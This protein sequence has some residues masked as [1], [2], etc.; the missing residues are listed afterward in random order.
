MGYNPSTYKTIT[1]DPRRVEEEDII[2]IDNTYGGE[3]VVFIQVKNQSL[4]SDKTSETVEPIEGLKFVIDQ[5]GN[6][7]ISGVDDT[8][9]EFYDN[10]NPDLDFWYKGEGSSLCFELVN[11][12][13][14][15]NPMYQYELYIAPAAGHPYHEYECYKNDFDIDVN[16]SK[17]ERYLEN[18]LHCHTITTPGRYQYAV[19]GKGE[20][21]GVAWHDQYNAHPVIKYQLGEFNFVPIDPNISI[22]LSSNSSDR[23]VMVNLG[24]LN[25]G[26]L[27][28]SSTKYSIISNSGFIEG[29]LPAGTVYI[30]TAGFEN[31]AIEFI[32]STDRGIQSA[33]HQV[34]VWTSPERFPTEGVSVLDCTE[35]C[36][37]VFA[38]IPGFLEYKPRGLVKR[39]GGNWS[40][41]DNGICVYDDQPYLKKLSF[42]FS[43]YNPEVL[44]DPDATIDEET[45]IEYARVTS[46]V[47]VERSEEKPGCLLFRP[48]TAEEYFDRTGSNPE[49]PGLTSTDGKGI[50]P[51]SSP[52]T[53]CP[54]DSGKYSNEIS[55]NLINQ[56]RDTDSTYG[57][58]YDKPW[59]LLFSELLA[60]QEEIG[61]DGKS[62]CSIEQIMFL[63]SDPPSEA[64]PPGASPD[65]T[66]EFFQFTFTSENSIGVRT[67][68]VG[69]TGRSGIVT[70]MYCLHDEDSL[71][72][73]RDIKTP[74][75]VDCPPDYLFDKN[76]KLGYYFISDRIRNGRATTLLDAPTLIFH[77]YE[78]GTNEIVLQLGAFS[79]IETCQEALSTDAEVEN[80][81]DRQYLCER[82]TT[83]S[84]PEFTTTTT[85]TTT[86]TAAPTTTTTTTT[87][88]TAAPSLLPVPYYCGRNP[89]EIK[90]IHRNPMIPDFSNFV[91]EDF[92]DTTESPHPMAGKPGSSAEHNT[93]KY[94]YPGATFQPFGLQLCLYDTNGTQ[95]MTPEKLLVER[96][97]LELFKTID[98]TPMTAFGPD[99]TEDNPSSI[100]PSEYIGYF[101]GVVKLY[102]NVRFRNNEFGDQPLFIGDDTYYQRVYCTIKH[103]SNLW[104]YEESQIP[105][106]DDITNYIGR[107]VGNL[108][109]NWFSDSCVSYD[110]VNC[111]GDRAVNK[112]KGYYNNDPT[113]EQTI[114]A[115]SVSFVYQE[116]GKLGDMYSCMYVAL[117]WEHTGEFLDSWP[118]YWY[119]D[120]DELFYDISVLYDEDGEVK[121][122]DDGIPV[123]NPFA[124]IQQYSVD[125]DILAAPPPFN[126]TS[127]NAC[128][129]D[130]NCVGIPMFGRAFKITKDYNLSIVVEIQR[131]YVETQ[132]HPIDPDGV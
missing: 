21:I 115:T 126:G 71:K 91:L 117:M 81:A 124:T 87:T 11:H 94:L 114:V 105:N 97:G 45:M 120:E 55:L 22:D 86:T 77:N 93:R 7:L 27:L 59:Q 35:D 76:N 123:K 32:I 112:F 47:T 82:P 25:Y 43:L 10:Y 23:K 121:L 8:G 127:A 44:N 33:K 100:P 49:W 116:A 16:Y 68:T 13:L 83:T 73:E 131:Q 63:S 51:D 107:S 61:A 113:D 6:L 28:N 19:A 118:N 74:T 53:V 119:D 89:D 12:S 66:A 132:H 64:D 31:D 56:S 125:G 41:Y 88:T 48:A 96:D 50:R 52:V 67:R 40:I 98:G 129:E 1:L 15:N 111:N 108:D 17:G 3:H 84:A 34:Y 102:E 39:G 24:N 69:I 106:F 85:T 62:P 99:Q 79:T 18:G 122:D 92:A 109:F 65:A 72:Q 110:Y 42:S 57:Y 4:Y 37:G 26:G 54:D 130:G 14:N 90:K 20:H 38:Q 70:K 46:Y 29:D 2:T 104:S 9:T 36:K 75:C 78:D 103:P 5:N 101:G 95:Y 80:P 58:Q 60:Y 128:D 30:P